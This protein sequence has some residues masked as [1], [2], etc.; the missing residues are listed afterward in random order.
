M[1][2]KEKRDC[3]K[4]GRR[5]VKYKMRLIKNVKQCIDENRKEHKEN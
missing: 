3:N 5:I 2:V 1:I 4:G